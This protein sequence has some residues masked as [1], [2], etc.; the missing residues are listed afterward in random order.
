M[1]TL[2]ERCLFFARFK[3]T[4]DWHSVWLN[5]DQV[6]ESTKFA[7]FVRKLQ[8]ICDEEGIELDQFEC[9]QAPLIEDI[10]GVTDQMDGNDEAKHCLIK[11]SDRE[12]D[13]STWELTK[14][15]LMLGGE[16]AKAGFAILKANQTTEY[17]INHDSLYRQSLI[18]DDKT[19][20][21]LNKDLIIDTIRKKV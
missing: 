5:Y 7:P 16:K 18:N 15:A 4:S 8:K 3:E 9:E 10:L 13:R 14:Y 1:T 12:F 11:W 20:L 19:T 21:I 2:L 17:L 6:S